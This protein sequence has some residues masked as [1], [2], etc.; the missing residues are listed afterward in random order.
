M[1]EIGKNLKGV[2]QLKEWNVFFFYY[3]VREFSLSERCG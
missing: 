1:M 3:Y 2:G